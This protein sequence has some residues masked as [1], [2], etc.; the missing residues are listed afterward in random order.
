MGEGWDK[1]IRE[2]FGI[3]RFA[4]VFEIDNVVGEAVIV[5]DLG[6]RKEVEIEGV[7]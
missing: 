7:C 4:K 6:V 3:F 1:C 2:H 5:Q